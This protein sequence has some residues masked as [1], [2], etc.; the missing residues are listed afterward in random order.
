MDVCV[1]CMCITRYLSIRV[2][3]PLFIRPFA[4]GVY[5]CVVQIVGVAS[6]SQ[7]NYVLAGPLGLLKES[8]FKA[9][10]RKSRRTDDE[11]RWNATKFS[12][13]C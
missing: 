3:T 5:L 8:L 13:V 6:H 1:C 9:K 10:A 2:S 12:Q 11:S 4:S 7:T